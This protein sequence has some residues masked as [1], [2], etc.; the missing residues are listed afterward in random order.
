MGSGA[1]L[2]FVAGTALLG[3]WIGV[4]L[5]AY[6]RAARRRAMLDL[7]A[8]DGGAGALIWLAP[9]LIVVASAFWATAGGS[10]DPAT[11]LD[12]YVDDWRHGRPAE[13]GRW[14]VS[15]PGR[16][17][18][19]D[20]WERQSIALRNELARL[21]PQLASD[22]RLEPAAPLDA[23]RWVDAGRTDD[24][25]RRI[26]LEVARRETVRGWLLG[27][28]PT[29]SQQLRSIA[30]LGTVEL[31]PVP[32]PGPLPPGPWAEAWRIVDVDVLGVVLGG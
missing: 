30:R 26:A 6:R 7:P 17:Q 27:V 22:A 18:V 19:I 9:G 25:G 1:P 14:F 8:G 15:M 23:V 24:G 29:T 28:V 10:A 4:A 20:A 21:A 12:G 13:A 11:A 16:E 31:R 3:S 32:V 2:L 5:H